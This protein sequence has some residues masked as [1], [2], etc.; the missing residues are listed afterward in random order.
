[1]IQYKTGKA[2]SYGSPLIFGLCPWATTFKLGEALGRRPSPILSIWVGGVPNYIF[3]T[4]FADSD[5]IYSSIHFAKTLIN[6]NTYFCTYL[7]I[8]SRTQQ[9]LLLIRKH[10]LNHFRKS[11]HSRHPMIEHTIHKDPAPS[12]V[13]GTASGFILHQR[14][15]MDQYLL[16]TTHTYETTYQATPICHAGSLITTFLLQI[17]T[18]ILLIHGCANWFFSS[19]RFW[20]IQHQPF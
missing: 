2:C 20:D 7:N 14:E 9:Q 18:T 6:I 12:L 17:K 10:I 16:T 4:T 13:K 15:T 19:R 1:M 8:P 5:C 11:V 3:P